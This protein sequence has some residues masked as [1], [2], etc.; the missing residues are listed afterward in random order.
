MAV[1]IIF[2]IRFKREAINVAENAM[3]FAN[4]ICKALND[5]LVSDKNRRV[6]VSRE[7]YAK[8]MFFACCSSVKNLHIVK[9]RCAYCATQ[10]IESVTNCKNCGGPMSEAKA[11][12][13]EPT[14][15]GI[16]FLPSDVVNGDEW[17]PV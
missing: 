7:N 13:I 8:I 6:Y 2:G 10:A 15:F 17:L 1:K 11:D 4:D 12:K 9:S 5:A 16:R 3:M 14:F